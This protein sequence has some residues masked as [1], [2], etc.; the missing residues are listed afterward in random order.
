MR[1]TRNSTMSTGSKKGKSGKKKSGKKGEK[2][3]PAA[4]TENPGR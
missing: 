1:K 4:K 3:K 2:K